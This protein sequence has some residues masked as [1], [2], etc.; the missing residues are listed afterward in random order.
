[1]LHEP[2]TSKN[3]DVPKKLFAE[4]IDIEHIQPYNDQN[5]KERERIKQTWGEEINSLG[6]LIVLESDINRSNQNKAYVIKRAKLK[7]KSKYGIVQNLVATH[8]DWNLGLAK[9]RKIIEVTKIL[10]YLFPTEK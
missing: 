4:I 6:N 3:D 1:M 8:N 9:A 7:E 2:Y 10:D 5:A